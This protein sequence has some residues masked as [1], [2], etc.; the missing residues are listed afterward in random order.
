MNQRP[1]LIAIVGGRGAGKTWMARHLQQH[2]GASVSRLSLRD[3][4]TARV[5]T[6]PLDE[7]KMNFDHPRCIN[8]EQFEHDLREVRGGKGVPLLK[9]GSTN[10]TE[11]SE[12]TKW[13][14]PSV[15]LVDGLW[16]LC[17]RTVRH[18]FDFSIYLD[19]PTQL[20]LERQIAKE[21]T[22]DV[23]A[24]RRNFWKIIAP[25]H[26]RFVV[27]EAHYADIVV[28]QPCGAEELENLAE[29]IRALVAEDQPLFQRELADA[30][31]FDLFSETS[32]A[33]YRVPG[34]L[35]DSQKAA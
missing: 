29:M 17:R 10:R 7:E 5:P 23:D 16:L 9:P 13:G 2:L 24:V 25:M 11:P 27:P 8:W 30:R 3:F 18:L 12:S 31:S 35:A 14:P 22:S 28:H 21:G 26:E 19:C 1:K 33:T 15:I 4:S 6:T 34:D 20:R 32:W